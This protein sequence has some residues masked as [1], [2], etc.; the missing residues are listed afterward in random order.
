MLCYRD[1]TFCPFYTDCKHGHDCTRA[2]KPA[3][4]KDADRVGLP[5]SSWLDKP[6]CFEERKH[7][8]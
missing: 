7:E 8:T 1:R 2:E 4:I 6:S 5:I 3:V